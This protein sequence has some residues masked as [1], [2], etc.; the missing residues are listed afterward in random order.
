MKGKRII[1]I[2]TGID[3]KEYKKTPWLQSQSRRGEMRKTRHKYA[4]L[5]RTRQ[6]REFQKIIKSIDF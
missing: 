2:Y 3:M 1:E 5:S 4:K 6:N